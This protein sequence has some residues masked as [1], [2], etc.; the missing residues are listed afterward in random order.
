MCHT[1]K[2][3]TLEVINISDERKTLKTISALKF[4]RKIGEIMNRAVYGHEKFVV[5]KAHKPWVVIMSVEDYEDMQDMIDTLMEQID[6]D[7]QNS[8]LESMEEYE[9]GE[10]LSID[11]LWEDLKK[12]EKAS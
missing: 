2:L 9:K 5:E 12:K 3:I 1:N 6:K 7:F 8:L 11:D 10:T 4:R